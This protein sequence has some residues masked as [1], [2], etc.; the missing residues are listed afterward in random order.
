M[1]KAMSELPKSTQNTQKLLF[2]LCLRNVTHAASMVN[3]GSWRRKNEPP[4]D[5][6]NKTKQNRSES[7]LGTQSFCWFC[8][9]EEK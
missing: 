8:R 6:T 9:E 4:H 2:Q 1:L 3:F 5:K 7:L